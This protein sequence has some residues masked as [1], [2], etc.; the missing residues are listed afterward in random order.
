MDGGLTAVPNLEE[1]RV[2][3]AQAARIYAAAIAAALLLTG[4]GLLLVGM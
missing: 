3:R 2:L 4:L 1:A